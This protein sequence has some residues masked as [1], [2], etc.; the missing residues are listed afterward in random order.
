MV[1]F[2]QILHTHAFQHCLTTGM[3][4]LMEEALLSIS[5]TSH[6]QL[7][8]VLITLEP[9]GIFGSNCILI[10]FNIVHPLV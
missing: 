5:A 6:G 9:H 10:Y 1:Y 8:K 4:V 2:D 3:R 7:V